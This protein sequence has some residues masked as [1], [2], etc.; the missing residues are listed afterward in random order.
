[1]SRAFPGYVPVLRH[2]CLFFGAPPVICSPEFRRLLPIP[3]GTPLSRA[4]PG[5]APVLRHACLFFGAL[6]PLGFRNF[7]SLSR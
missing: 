1:L 3:G 5:Y 6:S 4:L 7:S 2:A